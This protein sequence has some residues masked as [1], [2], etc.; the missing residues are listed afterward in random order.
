MG[1]WNRIGLPSMKQPGVHSSAKKITSWESKITVTP[2]SHDTFEKIAGLKGLWSPPWSTGGFLGIF[3]F[4]YYESPDN[5]VVQSPIYPKQPGVCSLLTWKS[6]RINADQIFGG[7]RSPIIH[8]KYTSNDSETPWN[9]LSSLP[10]WFVVSCVFS[11]TWFHWSLLKVQ[12][13]YNSVNS[14]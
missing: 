4:V 10:A 5:W 13:Q 3:I 12:L 6:F 9:S 14:Q 1:V 2:P 8:L 7:F 11:R